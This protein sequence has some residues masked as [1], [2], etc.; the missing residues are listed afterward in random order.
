MS[1]NELNAPRL[2]DAT[3]CQSIQELMEQTVD[4]LSKPDA[5]YGLFYEM[6]EGDPL[7]SAPALA[8]IIDLCRAILFPGFYGKSTLSSQTVP[9]HIGVSLDR[10]CHLL[11]QQVIAGLCFQRGTTDN[12][13]QTTDNRQQTTDNGQ[14]QLIESAQAIVAKFIT[15]L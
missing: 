6:G 13:Q 11:T 12:R 4:R 14:C 9:Y 5:M 2:S 7:P 15:R 8:E 3:R 1:P 10:L